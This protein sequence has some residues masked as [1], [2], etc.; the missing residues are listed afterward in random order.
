MGSAPIA[1][2]PVFRNLS[3]VLNLWDNLRLNLS[4]KIITEDY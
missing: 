3:E 1:V 4:R 2:D